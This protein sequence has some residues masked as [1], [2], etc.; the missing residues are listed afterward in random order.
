MSDETWANSL[1]LDLTPI[2]QQ[3]TTEQKVG[4]TSKL[5]VA[6]SSCTGTGSVSD[7]LSDLFFFIKSLPPS[8]NTFSLVRDSDSRPRNPYL[9]DTL[10]Q[11]WS[12]LGLYIYMRTHMCV[13]I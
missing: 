8:P 11:L 6:Q 13:Y 7:Y 3:Q 10:L 1:G 5:Y 12:P 4:H 9:K 2:T